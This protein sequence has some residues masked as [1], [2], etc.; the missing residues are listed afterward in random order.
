M[1]A[2]WIFQKSLPRPA[3]AAFGCMN[4]SKQTKRSWIFPTTN[5]R[6][7]WG[8]AGAEHRVPHYRIRPAG[9]ACRLYG[10]SR[11][12]F[13]AP[14]GRD[15]GCMNPSKQTKK[16]WI[17]PTTNIRP[18][19]GHAGAEH[20]V[21]H[22]RIRPAGAVCRLYGG[23]SKKKV[24]LPDH[25]HTPGTSNPPGACHASRYFTA[26]SSTWKINVAF[27]GMTLPAPASP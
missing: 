3:G 2:V 19:W 16:F 9:A 5:I 13:P 20:S 4:P 1:S 12:V 24:V 26:T 22:Y 14:Q 27:G 21:P 18:L 10:Y 6:P 11:K 15:V 25:P 8:H 7:L 23:T 17:F